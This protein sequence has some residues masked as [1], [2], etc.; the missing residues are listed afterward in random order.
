MRNTENRHR[1]FTPGLALGLFLALGGLLATLAAAAEPD[2]ARLDRQVRV[3]KLVIDELLG[4]RSHGVRRPGAETRG[5]ALEEFGA[6]FIVEAS[7]ETELLQYESTTIKT[8]SSDDAKVMSK[9]KLAELGQ[10]LEQMRQENEQLHQKCLAD[11]RTKLIDVL[12]DYGPTLT[13]LRDDHWV[14]VAAYPQCVVSFR[15]S[16]SFLFLQ[17]RMSDLR[18]FDDGKLSR[19]ATIAKIKIDER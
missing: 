6:L 17:L 4:P 2:S 16:D 5:L 8:M 9:A 19:E 13:A 3:M 18:Q 12:L 10:K 1:K 11:I 15:R 7:P 14:A